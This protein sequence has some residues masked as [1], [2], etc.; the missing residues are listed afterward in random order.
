[1]LKKF[2]L[3][4]YSGSVLKVDEIIASEIV[5]AKDLMSVK[6]LPFLKKHYKV[7]E[8]DVWYCSFN[9]LSPTKYT[10]DFG[11]HTKFVLVEE[12]A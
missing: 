10:I 7:K 2:N 4:L 1:M 12:I 6:V 9:E 5:K 3:I 11:S 8:S